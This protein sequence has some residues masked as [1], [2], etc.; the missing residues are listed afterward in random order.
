MS[1]AAGKVVDVRRIGNEVVLS[2]PLPD[3]SVKRIQRNS[4]ESIGK[5]FERLKKNLAKGLPVGSNLRGGVELLRNDGE[6]VDEDTTHDEA[7][8]LLVELKIGEETFAVRLDAPE[9]DGVMS[10][11]CP[12]VGYPLPA[13]AQNLQF[14][15]QDDLDWTWFS[16]DDADVETEVGRGRVY[17][18][19]LEDV[20]KRLVVEARACD[21]A[22]RYAFTRP[23][24]RQA[25]ERTEALERLKPQAGC[26]SDLVVMTYN[27]LADAYSHTWGT[28]FP[29]FDAALAAPER[30]L[31]LVGEDIWRADPD[32]VALQ[33]VDKKWYEIYFE[34][35]LSSLGYVATSWCG[36]SGQTNEG[37]T[38]FFKESK[39]RKLE[40]KNIKLTEMGD[41]RINEWLETDE[42]AELSKALDKITSVA[43]LARVQ[44][45]DGERD[46]CVGNTHLFF[47]PGAAHIRILQAHALV[48]KANAFSKGSPLILCGDFNG[49]PQD[50]IIRYLRDGKI[51]AA[52][53]DWVHGSLFRW[54]GTS[55]RDKARDL[56]YILDDGRGY[57]INRSLEV[58][59]AADLRHLH[60]RGVCMSLCART[61]DEPYGAE[62]K[63]K[64]E[65]DETNPII[66]VKAH[67]KAG[68]TFKN[69]HKVAAFTLRRESGLDPDIHASSEDIAACKS[70][71]A[72]VKSAQTVGFQKIKSAQ[73]TLAHQSTPSPPTLD[74]N[75]TPAGCGL[76]LKIPIHLSSA[77]GYPDWTNY[78]GG[79]VGAL[80]YVW[81]SADAF[82]PRA[83]A[84][85]PPMSAVTQCVALPNAQFP[86][87]HVPVLARVDFCVDKFS[88]F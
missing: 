30:R 65:P 55:S 78:V 42:N 56:F 32:I 74:D 70:A 14:A 37:C 18:P 81:C 19:T 16:V 86:S 43:Q 62:C 36:K 59:N 23:V 31:Q 5:G 58:A 38:M 26:S 57:E 50:G 53:D 48:S 10:V 83:V 13:T 22:R 2:V 3:G 80:D 40:E 7:W 12:M 39:F 47:H 25:H 61:L 63:C 8:K 34:P 20:G 66:A 46:F 75:V 88:P 28:M 49:E 24:H 72:R 6:R 9:F 1:A 71:F 73:S 17:E 67:V 79:F 52:D 27:V 84:P 15:Q 85:L 87:D 35:L 11:D 64:D 77:S 68:C 41:A 69:C 54:G 51:D 60:E 29:Y 82:I 76:T 21:E 45:I 4:S 33:E 44:T